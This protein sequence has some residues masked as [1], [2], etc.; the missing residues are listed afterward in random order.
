MDG[1]W[2]VSLLDKMGLKPEGL[3]VQHPCWF[4]KSGWN[5][6]MK[7]LHVL[8]R[9]ETDGGLEVG[10]AHLAGI[11][12]RRSVRRF[13]TWLIRINVDFNWNNRV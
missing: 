6:L 4:G 10:E 7:S 3:L 11:S 1:A 12:M 8:F 13:Q 9:E 2:F 5:V